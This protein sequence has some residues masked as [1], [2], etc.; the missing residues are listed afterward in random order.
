MAMAWKK[1]YFYIN[2]RT[3]QAHIT[4]M[5]IKNKSFLQTSNVLASPSNVSLCGF[6]GK[7]HTSNHD[8]VQSNVQEV[9]FG[10]WSR[11]CHSGRNCRCCTENNR[12][13]IRMEAGDGKTEGTFRYFVPHPIYS[14]RKKHGK[15]IVIQACRST[16]S[17]ESANSSLIYSL[18]VSEATKQRV[19]SFRS[20]LR[21]QQPISMPEP[22]TSKNQSRQA[23]DQSSLE[24]NSTPHV[25]VT[26]HDV[27]DPSKEVT[28]LWEAKWFWNKVIYSRIAILDW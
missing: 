15:L 9:S 17:Q 20:R 14:L 4:I 24:T 28:D 18:E 13:G 5:W 10:R 27:I 16:E 1:K 2:K 6:D 3:S 7:F 21:K 26:V 22:P 23:S 25:A 19:G 11:N 12:H 8:F